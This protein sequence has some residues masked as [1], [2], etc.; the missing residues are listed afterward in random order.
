MLFIRDDWFR[1]NQVLI[2]KLLHLLFLLVD[3]LPKH[4]GQLKVDHHDYQAEDEIQ[5]HVVVH[6]HLINVVE[7]A[8]LAG[9]HLF[10]ALIIDEGFDAVHHEELIPVV[11]G[12]CDRT[13]DLVDHLGDQPELGEVFEVL[14]ANLK[15]R[16]LEVAA[17]KGGEVN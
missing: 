5:K 17:Y 2:F 15:L 6:S 16:E 8:Q 1:F 9:D 3:I 4:V 11:G 13:Q 10:C 14:I 7:F 12:K